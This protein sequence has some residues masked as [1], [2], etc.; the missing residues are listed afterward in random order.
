[1]PQLGSQNLEFGIHARIPNSEFPIPNSAVAW[2]VWGLAA[3]YY[4]AAFYLRSS[5]AVMT[6]ELMRDFGISASQLG[7]FSAVYFYAYIAMQIPTGVL[8]DSWGA[9]RLLIGGAIAAATGTCLFGA[10]NSYA[11]ASI[12]R[13]IV[14]AATAVG[15]VV[16]LKLATHWFPRQRFAMLSG[17]GLMMGNVGA[18]VAQVPLRVLVEQFGWR[19]VAF[20]S[21]GVVLA[22]G[23]AAWAFVTND[24]L[25][26]GFRSCAPVELQRAHLTIGQLLREFPTIFTYRNTWLI[27][28]A[29]GGF[30]GAMLSFTGLWGPTYLRQRFTLAPTEAA[31]VCSV[32]IVCWAVASPIAGYL[33]D[34]IGRRKPIYL[35]GALVSAAGWS[36]LF[37]A[38]L[39]L[40]A[41][42][43]VA[44]IT[45]FACGAVVLGFAFA[46]ESVPVQLL[47]TI[48]GAI[49]VGNMLGPTI[50]QPAIG[51]VLD[52]RWAGATSNGVRIYSVD[53]FQAGFAMIVVWSV[54]TCVLIAFTRE[55]RCR[56][57]A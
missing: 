11:V 31:A 35:G 8:V 27:F 19:A 57:S 33:S 39:P 14:G 18:L 46:K 9:R 15:W 2:S 53:A 56:P 48:S 6:T 28:L 10:T 55:T 29:Q 47:G 43:V 20:G 22:V 4:L 45:S 34:T 13:L 37:F 5:P 52:Q 54:L 21:A 7:N 23:A 40:A 30:V 49:N 41:F 50:L 17:L 51:R 36:T 42:T 16:T 38:P 24:P 44:A 26:R 3:T 32:M 25:E 12:G 1:M